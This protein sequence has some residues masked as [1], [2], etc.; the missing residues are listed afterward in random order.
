MHCRKPRKLVGINRN[1]FLEKEKLT[2]NLCKF[3]Y[4]NANGLKCNFVELMFDLVHKKH[5]KVLN[6][7]S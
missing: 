3:R 2:K 6:T 5:A 1:C 4:K 7:M